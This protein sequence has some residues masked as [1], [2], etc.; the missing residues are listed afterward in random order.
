MVNSLERIFRDLPSET[1][2]YPGHGP[3]EVTLGSAEQY[4]RMFL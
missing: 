1:V 2:I 3:W 4:A